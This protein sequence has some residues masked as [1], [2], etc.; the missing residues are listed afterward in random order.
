MTSNTS[1]N[2]ISVS[3]LIFLTISFDANHIKFWILIA[4]QLL[5]I[6]CFLYIFLHFV[7]KRQLL[8]SHHHHVILLLFIV[9]FL[10]VTIALLFTEAY[11]YLSHVYPANAI[12]CSFWK[13]IHYSLKIINLFLMVF[14]SI[15]P[16]WLIFVKFNILRRKIV[17]VSYKLRLL[18]LFCYPH[19]THPIIID[20]RYIINGCYVCFVV[21]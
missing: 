15:E 4:L 17:S 9:S 8:K 21:L 18:R 20:R 7:H 14:A 2:T 11:M 16:N 1:I 6:S 10:F 5:S 19:Y 3:T 12:F 13:W